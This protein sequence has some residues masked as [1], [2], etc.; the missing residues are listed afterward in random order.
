[1]T[2]HFWEAAPFELSFERSG[3]AF[4]QAS[5]TCLPPAIS[6]LSLSSAS[7]DG[8]SQPWRFSACSQHFINWESFVLDRVQCTGDG[9]ALMQTLASA[10]PR[11]GRFQLYTTQACHGNPRVGSFS[12]HCPYLQYLALDLA[13]NAEA[14]P[15]LGEGSIAVKKLVNVTEFSVSIHSLVNYTRV[16][17]VVNHLRTVFRSLE[18]TFLDADVPIYRPFVTRGLPRYWPDVVNHLQSKLALHE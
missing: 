15:P 13:V 12:T 8:Y 3:C 1:M 9:D 18:H 5:P 16:G 2:V 4:I 17:A 6:T 14:E 7:R 10:W 11:L